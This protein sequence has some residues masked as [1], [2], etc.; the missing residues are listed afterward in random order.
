MTEHLVGRLLDLLHIMLLIEVPNLLLFVQLGVKVR[1]EADLVLIT[2]YPKYL[3]V[4]TLP[5]VERCQLRKLTFLM[6]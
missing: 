3:I 5:A 6:Y 1:V 4:H 2:R